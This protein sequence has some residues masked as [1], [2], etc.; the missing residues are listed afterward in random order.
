MTQ[1]EIQSRLSA[2][3]PAYWA[4]KTGLD[5]ASISRW[6]KGKREMTKN[7]LFMWSFFFE[8][9]QVKADKITLIEALGI[10]A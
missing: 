2:Q 7:V 8:L 3:K 9:E 5:I 10:K 6:S 1:E 4:D